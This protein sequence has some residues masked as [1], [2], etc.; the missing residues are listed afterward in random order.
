MYLKKGPQ[1]TRIDSY[2]LR[3][4]PSQSIEVQQQDKNHS[5]QNI[6]NPVPV[7]EQTGK[8]EKPE[9]S[10]LRPAA[11]EKFRGKS[12]LIR[13]PKS[14]EKDHVEGGQWQPLEHLTDTQKHNHE[15]VGQ[16]GRTMAK[17]NLEW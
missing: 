9:L 4:K 13:W 2:L 11:E 14:C 5:L 10:T 7:E 17:N 3:S 6:K 16:N 15:K 12:P 1:S 8:G